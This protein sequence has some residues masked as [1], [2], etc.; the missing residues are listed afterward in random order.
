MA[1]SKDR[2]GIS[3]IADAAKQS[4][5]SAKDKLA[6][7]KGAFDQAQAGISGVTDKAKNILENVSKPMNLNID[8]SNLGMFGNIMCGNLPTLDVKLPELK[9]DIPDLQFGGFGNVNFTIC[10]K[11]E[12][13]NPFDTALSIHNKL[14][15]PK[16][17]IG[18]LKSQLLGKLLDG[19]L[20][21]LL[22]KIGVS[23][24]ADCLSD[25]SKYDVFDEEFGGFG[26]PLE[27]RASLDDYLNKDSCAQNVMTLLGIPN[28]VK[29]NA[30]VNLLDTLLGRD[31]TAG[32]D[33]FGRV[34]EE[35]D[36]GR[37]Q[38]LASLV[39]A[40]KKNSTNDRGNSIYNKFSFISNDFYN[41][42][43]RDKM[44]YNII[45]YGKPGGQNAKDYTIPK[46]Y[47]NNNIPALKEPGAQSD[48]TTDSKDILNDLSK[49]PPDQVGKIDPDNVVGGLTTIDPSWGSDDKIHNTKDNHV[50]EHVADYYISANTP[51]LNLTGNYTTKLNCMHKVKILNT[52][53]EKENLVSA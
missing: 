16:G 14:K 2:V 50:M 47:L 12:S 27:D 34:I 29:R 40:F 13:M 6:E 49:L 38:T 41:K 39:G 23:G 36:Y 4:F 25:R 10:G 53:P 22:D 32:R 17:F 18:S 28:I 52:F 31:P 15:D 30:L 5:S 43:D 45:W 20:G 37:R 8:T 24:I 11:T 51:E 3:K 21:G 1:I 9:L 7:A 44:N 35:P 46:D 48:W 19:A 26:D 33:L 42:G